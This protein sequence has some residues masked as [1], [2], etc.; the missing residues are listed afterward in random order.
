M[1]KI[2]FLFLLCFLQSSFSY[3]KSPIF[4]DFEGVN[5]ME[6]LDSIL[7]KANKNAFEIKYESDK[8]LTVLSQKYKD[9]RMPFMIHTV[10]YFFLEGRFYYGEI[11]TKIDGK[12]VTDYL[13][14]YTENKRRYIELGNSFLSSESSDMK[15]SQGLKASDVS[16]QYKIKY[17]ISLFQEGESDYCVKESYS[18]VF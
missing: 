1:K 16:A 13:N 9:P 18:F 12:N 3:G 14:Y 11:Y 4:H 17:E 15:Y 2:V 7:K 8:H 5:F 6:L 10:K